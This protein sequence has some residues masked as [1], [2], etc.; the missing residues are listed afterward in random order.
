VP[1]L[2][3]TLSKRGVP[4]G[5]NS[6]G[7]PE[8]MKGKVSASFSP[9]MR[10]Y[11]GFI[12]DSERWQ[13]FKFRNDDI[14]ITTPSKCGTTWM[15]SIVGTLIFRGPDF[16]GPVGSI[17]LW[18]DALLRS[19]ADATAILEAQTHRRFLKTHT[20][21]DGL[22][23]I[24]GVTYIAVVRHPLD[25]ALSDFDHSANQ[26]RDRTVEL[27]NRSG[28]GSEDSCKHAKDPPQ[29]RAEFLRWWIDNDIEPD[30]AGPHG[31]A[32]FCQQVQTYGEA[33]NDPN[34]HLFHYSDLWN[35]LDREMRR[36]V[37][38]LGVTVDEDSWQEWVDSVKLA[39][40]RKRAH[41]TAPEAHL[42]LW[43]S[44]DQFFAKGGHRDW[45]SLLTKEDIQHFE[46]RLGSLAGDAT[47]WILN[48]RDANP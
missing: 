16:G 12:T 5:R 44:A 34:V 20:P 27:V 24:P 6:T 26:C 10:V 17:S 8:R 9:K 30:G 22:P 25:V 43:K 37:D 38:I 14:V 2:T 41:M 23:R 46:S 21:L 11:R 40:M 29:D 42:G 47:A 1:S 3:A 48:G 13:R 15:Q 35:N 45:S 36:L 18:L 7:Q 19:E 31:L 4:A 28:H 32:D 33:R 39:S